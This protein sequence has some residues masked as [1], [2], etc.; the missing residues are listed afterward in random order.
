MWKEKSYILDCRVLTITSLCEP[1]PR[2][3]LCSGVS[4]FGQG[5]DAES[6]RVQGFHLVWS[7]TFTKS[8][9]LSFIATTSVTD[10]KSLHSFLDIKR[11]TFGLDYHY[12]KVTY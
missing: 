4:C 1:H 11:C 8:P 3:S 12:D 9:A 5:V 7:F 2:P 6:Y 10:C